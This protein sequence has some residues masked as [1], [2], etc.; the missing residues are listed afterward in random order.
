MPY[1][2]LFPS[3]QEMDKRNFNGPDFKYRV[4]WRRV[5][6]SGPN[7]HTNY[8]TTPPFTV[9]DIGNFSAFEIKVQAVN[10]QGEGP[11]PDPVIGYSGEDGKILK[12]V[13]KQFS[14][15]LFFS[16]EYVYFV[17]FLTY[18]PPVFNWFSVPLEAPMDV[19]VVL[20]NSTTIRVT[21]AA[22]DRETVRGHLLGY[23]VL[24]L[25]LLCC[26]ASHIQPMSS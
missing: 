3:L 14:N 2:L 10:E 1:C 12:T 7:W 15:T 24:I 20:M 19:G 25:Y 8:T 11:E 5:V 23:K 4:L 13:A 26:L 9:N 22:V 21:W 17:F 6:G 18:H 16:W